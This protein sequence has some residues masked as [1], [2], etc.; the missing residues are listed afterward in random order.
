[1][2]PVVK[3]IVG[4]F[5]SIS[6]RF[7]KIA[8]FRF[9]RLH[10]AQKHAKFELHETSRFFGRYCA[11]VFTSLFHLRVDGRQV[12]ARAIRIHRSAVQSGNTQGHVMKNRDV[13]AVWV[14]T[15][16]LRLK[17]R[18]VSKNRTPASDFS[19]EVSRAFG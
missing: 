1:M 4:A 9:H 16:K 10:L 7:F 17:L 14:Y 19:G 18:E 11:C 6:S 12:K 15:R 13:S 3:P 2:S 8:K 5:T